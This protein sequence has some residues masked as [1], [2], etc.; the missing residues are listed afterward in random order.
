MTNPEKASW[1]SSTHAALKRLPLVLMPVLFLAL[2]YPAFLYRRFSLTRD[3]RPSLSQEESRH[4]VEVSDATIGQKHYADAL[5]PTARLYKAYPDNHIYIGRMAD[6]ADHLAQ[7]GEAA[8]YWEQYMDHAPSPIE[9][10]PQIGQAYW[11]Q[12]EKFEPQAIVAYQRC[13]ALN[14][15]NTD[16][17]FYLA[18]ALEMSGQWAQAA[19]QYQKGLSISPAYTDLTLGLA[20][21]WLRMDKAVDAKKLTILVLAEHPNNSG[22]LLVQGMYYLH[23]HNYLAAK[24]AL[25]AGAQLAGRDPDFNVL[26]ARVAEDTN[27]NAEA[28]RQYARVLEL[29]PG[30]EQ[31]RSRRDSLQTILSASKQE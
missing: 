2:A 6:I 23:Q 24:R 16:S 17:I 22:A 9:A 31:A 1:I 15:N 14:P 5:D 13:L 8:K 11:K 21:C 10:C 18:H 27:D 4:L 3:V 28:L 25:T 20:R 19:E 26:L 30:N 29:E 12:G 7:Y